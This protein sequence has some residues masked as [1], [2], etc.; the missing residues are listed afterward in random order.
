VA[1]I[2]KRYW[3]ELTDATEAG[4]AV[5][6]AAFVAFFVAAVTGILSLLAL[7]SVTQILSR[8]AILDA[9]LFGLLGIFILRGSRAAAVLALILYVVEVLAAIA[10]TGNPG[11]LV[12]GI[13]FTFAFIN[14][15]RGAYSLKRLEESAA[16]RHAH[17]SRLSKEVGT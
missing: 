2:A 13:I 12:V 16:S 3:P 1:G 4:K 10:V 8:W 17:D 5:K 14:G 7:L 11:G 15:V 9:L 6:G